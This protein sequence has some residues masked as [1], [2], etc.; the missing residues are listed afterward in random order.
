MEWWKDLKFNLM[1]V[2][3]LSIHSTKYEI[4]LFTRFDAF[5]TE[6]DKFAF[7]STFIDIDKNIIGQMLESTR[8]WK[9][10]MICELYQ[11]AY[12]TIQTKFPGK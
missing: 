12:K 2:S 9:D 4:D 1:K 6:T 8:K 5:V 11:R 10:N 7:I 3:F